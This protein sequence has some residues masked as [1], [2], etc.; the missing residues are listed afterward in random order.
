MVDQFLTGEFLQKLEQR[1]KESFKILYEKFKVPLYHLIHSILKDKEKTADIIQDT[2]IKAIKSIHQLEDGKKI[3]YWIFRIA[4]NLSL[5]AIKKDHRLSYAG[6]DLE[7]IADQSVSKK[8]RLKGSEDLEARN[9]FIRKQVEQLPVK[10]RLPF[11]LKYV[12]GL[13]ETE[14]GEILEIPVGTVKSRLNAA[15]SKIRKLLEE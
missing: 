5:N 3:K 11:N 8:F 14:I 1:D 13:K 4:V 15:K 12:Q 10:H 2:F 6:D 7:L 9:Y